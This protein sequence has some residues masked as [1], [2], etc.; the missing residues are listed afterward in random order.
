MF[1]DNSQCLTC[2]REL[3]FLPDR[4]EMH[5]FQAGK[6]DAIEI[7]STEGIPATRA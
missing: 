6:A 7:L 5:A 3:G 2:S 1:F 4:L